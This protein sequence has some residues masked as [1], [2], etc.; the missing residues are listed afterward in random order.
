[1][2]TAKI[3]ARNLRKKQTPAEAAFWEQVR[4]RRF[5]N[6]KFNRQHVIAFT[7][8][9]ERRFFIADFYCAEKKLI[10]EIDGG[11][12]EMQEEYDML[13]DFL[14]KERQCSVIRFSNDE[15]LN[16]MYGVLERLNHELTP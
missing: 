2:T 11:V 5:Q 13:R 12:H 16:R 3:T 10:V 14:L 7:Y 15:V 8:D 1:L 4:N 9:E 6:M